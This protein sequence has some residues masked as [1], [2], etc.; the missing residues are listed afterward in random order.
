[1]KGLLRV[2]EEDGQLVVYDQQ[3]VEEEQQ[4][5]LTTVFEDG[6]LFVKTDLRTIR[7]NISKGL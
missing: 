7:E 3:T 2:E 5:V 4:G 6:K 1:L